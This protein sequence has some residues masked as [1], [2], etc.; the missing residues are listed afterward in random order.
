MNLRSETV[1]LQGEIILGKLL[2]ID[3][4]N[5]ALNVTS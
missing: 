2:D 5:N 1:K 4:A 3:L